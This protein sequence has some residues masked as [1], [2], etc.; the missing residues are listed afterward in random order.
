MRVAAGPVMGVLAGEVVGVFAHVEPAEQHGTGRRQP[1]DQ[2]RVA[3]GRLPLA[4]DLRARPRR[5]AFNVEQV[6]GRKGHARQRPERRTGGAGGIDR[7]R[8]HQRPLGRDV[9][10]GVDDRIERRDAGEEGLRD[11]HGRDLPLPNLR[12]DAVGR[13]EDINAH[14]VCS[15]APGRNTGAS[16]RTSSSIG[17]ARTISAMP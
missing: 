13:R 12:R 11:G 10:E 7:T 2:H 5:Q 3:R 4:I 16:S 15:D 17:A 14:V 8:L 9:G 6:L 1:L